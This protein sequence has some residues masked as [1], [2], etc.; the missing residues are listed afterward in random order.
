MGTYGKTS[1]EREKYYN[2]LKSARV[3]INPAS[4]W[5]GYSSTIEAMYYGCPIIVSPYDD[6]IEEFGK[7]IPFGYYLNRQEQLQEK[8]N[9]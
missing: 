3:L 1:P 7:L 4:K 9:R 8:W 2:L 6:F 5:G